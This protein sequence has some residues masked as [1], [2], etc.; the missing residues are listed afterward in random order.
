[1]WCP[2]TLHQ[3]AIKVFDLSQLKL[4]N[5]TYLLL[6]V[7]GTYYTFIKYK[8]EQNKI[9]AK[10]HKMTHDPVSDSFL[11]HQQTGRFHL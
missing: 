4:T 9:C 5:A 11:P 3:R 8:A 2:A 6:P 7:I 1:M 10:S